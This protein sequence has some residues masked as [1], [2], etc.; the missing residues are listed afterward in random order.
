MN[1]QIDPGAWGV[2]AHREQ[3]DTEQPHVRGQREV[4]LGNDAD[5][6]EISLPP[7][8]SAC[9]TPQPRRPADCHNPR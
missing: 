7:F 5:I 6:V 9:P 1:C 3:L 8:Y 2:G 4:A